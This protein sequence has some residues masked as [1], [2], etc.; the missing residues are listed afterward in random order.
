MPRHRI[1]ATEIYVEELARLDRYA[2]ELGR[3][4]E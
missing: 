3:R 2:R 1:T 4:D